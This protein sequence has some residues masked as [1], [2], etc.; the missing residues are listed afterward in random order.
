LA[1]IGER[2]ILLTRRIF[3]EIEVPKEADAQVVVV[4]VR[5]MIVV[6]VETVS[7]EVAD[8]DAIVV[9]IQIQLSAFI[10]KRWKL[11][12]YG[13]AAYTLSFLNFIGSSQKHL[14]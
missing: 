3:S 12:F 9:R 13:L 5:G 11:E 1:E 6:D 2:K 8:A 4:V 7:V 14:P 10:R